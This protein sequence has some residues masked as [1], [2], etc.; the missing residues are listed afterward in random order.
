[1]KYVALV[2]AA[3]AIAVAG[4]SQAAAQQSSPD[5]IRLPDGFQPEGIAIA[6]NTFYVGSIPTGAIYRGDLRTGQGRVLFPGGLGRAAIGVDHARVGSN[7]FDPDVLFVAGGPTG[8]AFA[9]SARTGNPL[10]TY[11][12][13]D[14]TTFVNDVVV[15]DEGA[16]F[17]D[18][19]NQVLY[20]VRFGLP[21]RVG[22]VETVPLTG[23]LQYEPGFNVNGIDATP[24]G[25]TL[26]LVQS[27]TG[28]L[29]TSTT[30]GVTREIDLGGATVR[31]GDGILLD[32][33]TLYVV[34]NRDNRIAVVALSDDL[35][36]GRITRFITDP[37]FDVP[38]TIDD[39]GESL[40]AVN[41]RFGTPS[42]ATARYD[43]VRVPK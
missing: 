7:P 28:E 12:L 19:I 1:M 5:L 43:V 33:R 9:Y 39:R 31:N 34:Q 30:A 20:F 8:K 22:T 41:A 10:A 2:L 24:D 27:N 32:G 11:E 18:S 17:T 21:R 23:D 6:G 35:R 42:P 36:S 14:A 16:W 29:F 26:V 40:Y 4:G 13:T 25:Q 3:V 15:R 38:T 37:D